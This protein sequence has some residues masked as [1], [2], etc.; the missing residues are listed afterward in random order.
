MCLLLASLAGLAM[1]SS[2]AVPASHHAAAQ[3]VP[4]SATASLARLRELSIPLGGE[5][6]GLAS[7]GSYL[8]AYV[9]DTG[10]LTRVDART[11]Q[12]RRFSLPELRGLP[13][14]V[15]A[16]ARGVWIANV[17]ST[18]SDLIRVDPLTGRID[19]RLRLPGT[20]SV[21]GVAAAYG[22]V[23]VLVPDAAFPPGWRVIRVN[24]ATDGVSG[25]SADTPGTQ[26]TGH[27]AAISASGGKLWI[28]GSMDL[29]VSMDPR[30]LAMRTV[31]T[32]TLS[33]GLV[34]GGGHAWMLDA[35]RPR[36]YEVNPGTGRVVRTLAT[37]PP[38]RTGRDYVA[39]GD[40]ALWVFRGTQVTELN[41]GTGQAVARTGT[42]PVAPAVDAPVIT[43]AGIWYLAQTS[44]GTAVDHV[45]SA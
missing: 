30:T 8:W 19:G 33:E 42:M 12:V 9:R 16:S 15:A 45:A 41:P 25:I 37:P 14:V 4:T 21:A 36:L 7:S 11:G 10:V 34:F 31:P 2:C 22:S 5:S 35:G 20:G 43:S 6:D 40:G 44:T 27:T 13:A 39:A 26:L 32:G 23:W 29:I 38:S 24:A 28:T 3:R 17:H 18:Y 1:L